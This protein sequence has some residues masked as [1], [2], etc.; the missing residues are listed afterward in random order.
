MITAFQGAVAQTFSDYNN[1]IL[2]LKAARVGACLTSSSR[3]FQNFGPKELYMPSLNKVN[4][5]MII[6]ITP[7]QSHVKTEK[8]SIPQS[9]QV[10]PYRNSTKTEAFETPSK[11][12]I[13]ENEIFDTH[14]MDQCERTNTDIF[15]KAVTSQNWSNMNAQ[16]GHFWL[17]ICK[18]VD[19]RE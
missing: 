6:I 14:C 13:H 9:A 17:H 16:N 4:I 3:L 18:Q 1:L 11:A 19:Q 15:E 2:L 5:I 7:L 10:D 12:N 8:T